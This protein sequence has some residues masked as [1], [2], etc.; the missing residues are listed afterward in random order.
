MKTS[1]ETANV[2][3]DLTYLN[4]IT[5]GDQDFI[6]S[7][8]ATYV[9]D[10]PNVIDRLATACANADWWEVGQAAHQLKPSLQFVGLNETLVRTKTVEQYCKQNNNLTLVPELVN[11]VLHD[12]QASITTLQQQ[13]S[14]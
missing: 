1:N 6:E 2:E 11:S 8:I 3:I 14:I 12:V 4:E 10:V 5:G 7:I 9:T 13:F